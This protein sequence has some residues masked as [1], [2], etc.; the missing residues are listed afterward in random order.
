MT[1]H[2]RATSCAGSMGLAGAVKEA[3]RCAERAEGYHERLQGSTEEW[4]MNRHAYH[5]AVLG[6]SRDRWRGYL[7]PG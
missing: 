2:W 1:C 3:R 7:V 6:F 5:T 4:S